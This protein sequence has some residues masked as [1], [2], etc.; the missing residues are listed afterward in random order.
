MNETRRV[1]G[2]FLPIIGKLVFSLEIV[3]CR[4]PESNS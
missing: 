2:F 3:R 1:E 4:V